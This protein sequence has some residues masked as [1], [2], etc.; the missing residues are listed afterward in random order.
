MQSTTKTSSDLE[1]KKALLKIGAAALNQTPIDWTG[2]KERI[3]ACIQEAQQKQVALL[4]LP[5]MCI[6]GYGCED[7]FLSEATA[8]MAWQ[9]LIEILPFTADIAVTLGLPIF[10]DSKCYNCVV[11]VSNKRILGIAAK[12]HLAGNGIHYEPRWFEPWPVGATSTLNLAT[13]SPSSTDEDIPFGDIIFNLEGVRV[14]FEICEDAWVAPRKSSHYKPEEIDI[15]LNPSASHFSFLKINERRRLVSNGAKHL[16][17]HYVL[18]NLLGN[19]AGRAIYDGCCIISSPQHIIAEGP[20]FSYRDHVLT[21]AEIEVGKEQEGDSG[22]TEIDS[23][24]DSDTSWEQSPQLKFE[25]FTRAASLS[26]FDY[27]RKCRAHGF[28]VSLSG[29]A[30]SAAT[31]CLIWTLVKLASQELS[32]QELYARL[33]VLSDM[34]CTESVTDCVA[35]LLTCVYQGTENSSETTRAAAQAVAAGIGAQYHEFDINPLVAAYTQLV[36]GVAQRTLTWDQDDLAL[37]NIQARVR[38]PG[39]WMLANLSGALLLCTSNRSEAAVGYATMD[40]DT[41]GSISPIAGLDKY[42]LLQWLKWL[43]VSGP[44]GAMAL[45]VLS[46]INAQAPTA[47]L[48][49]TVAHQTDEADLM[50]YQVLNEIE[51]AFVLRRKSISGV[52]S[53]IKDLHPD[54]STELLFTWIERFFSLWSRNQWKRERTAPSFHLDD[55]S[56]DPKTWCRFPI[57]SGGFKKELADL[58]SQLML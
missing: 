38:S 5:E 33:P 22:D 12:S 58:K 35:Q 9:I 49:P 16:N 30:D 28:I 13:L 24:S 31:A 54:C 46:C 44:E 4:C 43:E 14:G 11:L 2:N 8:Q 20:R 41:S 50:P 36:E 53:E 6:P 17:C 47:E 32:W 25:E 40:G 55:Q 45:P 29:G 52:F 18:S 15:I 19:E 1:T 48:R 56:L 10:K 7:L 21:I 51:Q 57:L 27:V 26:L 37:Q 3:L 42:T 23:D 34:P 39:V